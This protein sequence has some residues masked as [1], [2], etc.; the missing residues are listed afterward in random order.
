[1]V[2]RLGKKGRIIT[3]RTPV[4]TSP[5][6]WERVGILKTTLINQLIVAAYYMGASP[7]A[8]S[9]FYRRKAKKG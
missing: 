6:R 2:K 1:L 8:L 5:R 9:R 4:E 3:C 7:E